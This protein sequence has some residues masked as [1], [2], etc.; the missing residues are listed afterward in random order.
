MSQPGVATPL[1]PE[2]PAEVEAAWQWLNDRVPN[3]DARVVCGQVTLD[4]T[5][6]LCGFTFTGRHS[7]TPFAESIQQVVRDLAAGATYLDGDVW[8]NVEDATPF[9]P[10]AQGAVL[11]S[12]SELDSWASPIIEVERKADW[13]LRDQTEVWRG[14]ARVEHIVGGFPKE[15]AYGVRGEHAACMRVCRL[16]HSCCIP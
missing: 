3:G 5:R 11:F 6:Y 14:V 10:N 13:C 7:F 4:G 16:A 15:M 1:H 12:R 2:E 9:F 8:A